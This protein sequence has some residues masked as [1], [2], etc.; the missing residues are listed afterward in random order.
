MDELWV[1]KYRP[2]K[3]ED[4]VGQ[5][6]IVEELKSSINNLPH[7][8]FHGPAGVGKTTMAYIIGRE[9]FNNFKVSL[10]SILLN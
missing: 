8:L 3:F 6:S 4:V 1:E 5:D 7:L 9:L 2:K 10:F